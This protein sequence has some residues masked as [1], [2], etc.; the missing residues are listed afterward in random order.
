MFL[1]IILKRAPKVIIFHQKYNRFFTK[2]KLKFHQ[3][4][5]R[6]SLIKIKFSPIKLKKILGE[7]FKNL[8]EEIY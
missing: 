4:N 2:N 1:R 7:I 8:V 6:I 5:K 3:I